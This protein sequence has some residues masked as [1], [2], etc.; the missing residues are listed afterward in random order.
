MAGPGNQHCASCI[1]TLSFPMLAAGLS[2]CSIDIALA[3]CVPHCLSTISQLVNVLNWLL[4]DYA[5]LGGPQNLGVHRI[6]ARTVCWPQCRQNEVW[7]S[8]HFRA[9]LSSSVKSRWR[10]GLI[11]ARELH[12]RWRTGVVNTCFAVGVFT[13]DERQ[14]ANF[15]AKSSTGKH[16]C[17]EL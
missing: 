16:A 12:W 6:K 2:D 5:I 15:T 13:A 7:C 10:K 17:L 1:G 8:P 14:F 11:T 4:I 3:Q 9:T